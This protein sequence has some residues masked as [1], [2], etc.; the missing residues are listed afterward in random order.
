M[1]LSIEMETQVNTESWLMLKI[2]EGC[3]QQ[4]EAPFKIH[5]KK[6]IRMHSILDNTL[7][8]IHKKQKHS[9]TQI[10]KQSNLQQKENRQIHLLM[11]ASCRIL[12]HVTKV[13]SF[14]TGF[15]SMTTSSLYSNE[16]NR[17]PLGCGWMRHLH[18]Q[19]CSSCAMLSCQHEPKCQRNISS[20]FMNLCD[21]ESRQFWRQN[22]G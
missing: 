1:N 6:K 7:R 9:S 21:K 22:G 8:H 20:N 11:A 14:Q 3:R 19:I 13:R 18:W 4:K 2:H 12:C 5:F 17:A 10:Q 15:S 16:S